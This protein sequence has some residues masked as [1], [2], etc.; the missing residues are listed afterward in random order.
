MP[1]DGDEVRPDTVTVQRSSRPAEAVVTQVMVVW[2]TVTRQPT[3]GKS[4][5]DEVATVADTVELSRPKLLSGAK[6]SRVSREL[7]QRRLERTCRRW[8]PWCLRPWARS[9]QARR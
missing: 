5:G 9:R 1:P 8:S 6:R 7:Y 4:N 3:S 2:G